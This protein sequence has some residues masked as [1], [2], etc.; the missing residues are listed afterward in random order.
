MTTAPVSHS[1]DITSTFE[2]LS[3]TPPARLDEI[4]HAPALAALRFELASSRRAI[5]IVGGDAHTRRL[6]SLRCADS[7]AHLFGPADDGASCARLR[8]TLDAA[9]GGRCIVATAAREALVALALRREGRIEAVVRIGRAGRE[10]RLVA[11]RAVLKALGGEGAEALADASPAFGVGDF[12]RAVYGDG[13]LAEVVERTRPMTAGLDFVAYGSGGGGK[14]A[15]EGVWGYAEVKALLQR[16]VEWPVAHSDTFE[17]LGV[18]APRGV[19]LHGPSGCGKTAIVKSLLGGLRTSNWIRVEG[20]AI[21]SKYLGDSEARVRAMFEEARKLEPCV[22][23]IDEL[24]ALAGSRDGEEVSAVERRVLGAFLAELDGVGA[25]KVFV[26]ACTNM[27]ECVDA[28]LIRSGRIDNVILVGRPSLGDRK[29]ILD[30]LIASMRSGEGGAVVLNET[31]VKELACE[32]LGYTGADLA[33]L[34][35]DAA[36]NA[37]QRDAVRVEVQ[38]CDFDEALRYLRTGRS[39]LNPQCT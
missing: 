18:D 2:D 7:G 10:E 11:W 33:R 22:L 28:A 1:A 37:I 31:F 32:T 25:G 36:V 35:R 23:F 19:L 12:R 38:Q 16:L 4:L 24:E 17:R 3:L 15:W 9:P 14:V 8:R 5:L 21:Y 13:D 20:S 27:I 39:E 26:I 30:G 6:F 29:D 34:C